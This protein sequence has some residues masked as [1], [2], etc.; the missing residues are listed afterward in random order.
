[1]TVRASYVI[2][3]FIH[4]KECDAYALKCELSER[5]F[6][7]SRIEKEFDK[8]HIYL[9]ENITPDNKRELDDIV[10]NHVPI[11]EA[12]RICTRNVEITESFDHVTWKEV[13]R[14]SVGPGTYKLS[15]YFKLENPSRKDIKALCHLYD[16]QQ[17]FENLLLSLPA[18]VSFP[19]S[20]FMIINS[21]EKRTVCL[22]VKQT[23]SKDLFEVSNACL[24]FKRWHEHLEVEF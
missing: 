22:A 21:K 6:T 2:N 11:N 16:E 1:M 19:V 10:A 15:W 5:N 18:D 7:V 4:S 23:K 14:A 17:T 13:V 20:G 24:L 9:E 3:K 8:V 12:N